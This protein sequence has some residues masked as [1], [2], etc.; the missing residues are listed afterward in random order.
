MFGSLESSNVAVGRVMNI[1]I[2]MKECIGVGINFILG[3]QPTD[4]AYIYVNKL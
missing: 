3:G 2:T 1:P 4:H